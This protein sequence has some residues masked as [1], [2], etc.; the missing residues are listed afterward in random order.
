MSWTILII[1]LLA[2]TALFA[3]ERSGVR[4]TLEL[5]FK[6]D[7]KRESWWL[8]QYGQSVCTPVAALLVWD[9]DPADGLR[10]GLMVVAAVVAASL[11]CAILKRLIGRVRPGREDAGRFLGPSLKLRGTNHRESFPSSHSACAVALSAALVALYPQASATLWFL[12]VA[13][14]VLRYLLSAH[15]PSDVAGGAALGYAVAHLVFGC[16]P[17]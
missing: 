3:L 10:K 7:I 16:F 5:N 15:W 6:G 14:S 11:G 12:A 1:L 13:C 8:A 2:T 9:L 17:G 4:T